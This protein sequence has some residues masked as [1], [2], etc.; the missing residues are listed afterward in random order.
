MRPLSERGRAGVAR[1]FTIAAH[2]SANVQALAFAPHRYG[3][4]EVL[5]TGGDDRCV[6]LWAIDSAGARTA[7]SWGAGSLDVGCRRVCVAE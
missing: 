6:K 3:G 4:Y 7:D 2:G 1:G 5:A